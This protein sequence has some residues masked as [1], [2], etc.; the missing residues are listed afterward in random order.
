VGNHPHRGRG[1]EDGIR[2]SEGETG[3]EKAF[4]KKRKKEM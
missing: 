1:R 2:V 3:K 4:E